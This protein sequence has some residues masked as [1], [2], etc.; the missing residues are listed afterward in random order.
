MLMKKDSSSYENFTVKISMQ[1]QKEK[2][3]EINT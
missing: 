3:C 1:A 2:L